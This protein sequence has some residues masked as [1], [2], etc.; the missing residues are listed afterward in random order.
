MYKEYKSQANYLDLGKGRFE[1]KE[2]PSTT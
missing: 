2:K 1:E